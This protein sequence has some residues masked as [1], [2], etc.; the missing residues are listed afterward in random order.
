MNWIAILIIIAVIAIALMFE[1]VREF[2]SDHL[3]SAWDEIVDLPSDIWEVFSGIFENAAEFSP[4]GMAFGLGAVA[5]L[6]ISRNNI[7]KAFEFFPPTQKFLWMA[8][9]YIGSFAMSYLIGKRVF[10][11]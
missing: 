8:V 9:I 1:A 11:L 7:G 6:Y 2:L 3:G 5:V 4:V 10:E